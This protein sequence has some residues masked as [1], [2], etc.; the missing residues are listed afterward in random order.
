MSKIYFTK[1]IVP[2]KTNL[3]HASPR[4]EILT[5]PATSEMQ[6]KGAKIFLSGSLGTLPSFLF[7][8]LITFY[9]WTLSPDHGIVGLYTV[10]QC[11]FRPTCSQYTK[12][13]I[14]KYGLIAGVQAGWGQIKKC[15]NY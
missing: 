13:Q 1:Y 14:Q 15:H 11:T 3:P 5:D 7:A 9:Q 12:E 10:G 8:H 4:S 6:P 2:K